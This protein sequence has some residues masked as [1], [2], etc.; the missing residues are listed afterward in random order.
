MYTGCGVPADEDWTFRDAVNASVVDESFSMPAFGGAGQDLLNPLWLVKS[1]TNNVLAFTAKTLDLQ[2][3]N[4]NFEAGAAGPLLA[5]GSASDAVAE[6]RLQRAL[7]GG[8]DSLVTVEALLGLARHGAFDGDAPLIPSQGGAFVRLEPGHRG[9]FGILGFR[10]G[11]APLRPGPTPPPGPFPT[12]DVEEALARTSESAWRQARAEGVAAR[13]GIAL[14]GPRLPD[15]PGDIDLWGALGDPEAAAGA[16]L[17]AAAWAL[18][19]F[20]EVDQPIELQAAG[21]GGEVVTVI[22]GILS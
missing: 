15:G 5:L 7:A 10:S 12:A 13:R 4:D 3:A 17:L 11:Y 18:H 22:L 16:L 1:L 9:D 14:R 21:S 2:G 6:G 19:R 8:S 20:D